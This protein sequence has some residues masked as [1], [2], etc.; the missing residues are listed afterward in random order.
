MNLKTYQNELELYDLYRNHLT[1]IYSNSFI[2]G[3]LVV[4][5]LFLSMSY[6]QKVYR[7]ALDQ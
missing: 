3:C 4:F 1:V 5:T 6:K 2:R 7:D